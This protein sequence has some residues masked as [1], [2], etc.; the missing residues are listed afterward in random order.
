[1][2]KNTKTN[3]V[4]NVRNP[5]SFLDL[6]SLAYFNATHKIS[7]DLTIQCVHD[8]DDHF[9]AAKGRGG[10]TGITQVSTSRYSYHNDKEYF[11]E[12]LVNPET[13]FEFLVTDSSKRFFT[14]CILYMAHDPYK[15]YIS[16]CANNKLASIISSSINVPLEFS[17]NNCFRIS[18]VG[19]RDLDLYDPEF[20]GAYK[21]F[22]GGKCAPNFLRQHHRDSK[23]IKFKKVDPEA[24][25]P[26]K[27]RRSDT[28]LDIT[29]IKKIKTDEWGNEW[30]D[31]G[32]QLEVPAG[33]YTELYGRSSLIKK[34]W[35][36]ANCTGII[37]ETYR[38]NLMC[39][40]TRLHPDACSMETQLPN[41]VCQLVLRK[42]EV[43]HAVEVDRLSNT[44][45]DKGG[46]GSTGL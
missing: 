43:A 13:C 37:D 42:H 34:G 41:R 21:D 16:F 36:L 39:V 23:A 15:S 12:H 5:T 33:Y 3:A 22:F 44:E 35:Q 2:F 7:D 1:M 45:R 30:Y 46:F 18:G 31:T 29:V 27:K 26:S 14:A 40:F 28:G 8:H 20:G 19:F 17:N 38:N 32:L 24:V 9:G 10:L 6:F 4:S 25:L 11:Y